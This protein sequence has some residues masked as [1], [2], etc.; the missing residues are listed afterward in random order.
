MQHCQ[1]YKDMARQ[2]QYHCRGIQLIPMHDSMHDHSARSTSSDILLHWNIIHELTSYRRNPDTEPFIRGCRN[3]IGH[4]RDVT[5]FG[6]WLR[7]H[8]V[9]LGWSTEKKVIFGG[10]VKIMKVF[11]H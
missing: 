5:I 3:V 4:C 11:Y 6:R 2:V 7:W 10:T 1:F 9:G 8:L